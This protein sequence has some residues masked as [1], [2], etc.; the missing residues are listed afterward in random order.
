MLSVTVGW[1]YS[2]YSGCGRGLPPP[3][4]TNG[5][6]ARHGPTSGQCATVPLHTSVQ[7]PVQ[8]EGILGIV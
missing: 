3:P 6:E 2:D 8:V 7:S 4:T 1:S 5:T